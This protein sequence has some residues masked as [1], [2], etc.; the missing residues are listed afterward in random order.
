M[1]TDPPAVPAQSV[2]RAAGR[3]LVV[4]VGAGL[5]AGL[6]TGVVARG[7]MRLVTLVTGDDRQLTA[8][9]TIGVVLYFAVPI[10]PGAVARALGAR[11]TAVALL[12]LG[13]GYV[14]LACVVIGV[15]DLGDVDL[16]ANVVAV[17]VAIGIGFAVAVLGLALLAW[18]FASSWA[19]RYA[20][21][22]TWTE[23]PR[24]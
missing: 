15:Q 7:L 17:L 8:V 10:I 3:A 16:T 24:D 23:G 21:S 20:A 5:L 18:R 4:G 12:V 9:G 14:A 19:T 13:A 11:R 22:R 6:V 1:Q 2:G